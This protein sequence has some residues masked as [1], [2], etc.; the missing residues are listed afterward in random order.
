MPCAFLQLQLYLNF[1]TKPSEMQAAWST[2]SQM[3]TTVQWGSSPTSLTESATGNSSVYHY[4]LYTS[5]WQ[6][7]AVMTGL[8]LNTKYFYRVGDSATNA[9]SEVSSF[10]SNPGAGADID[11]VFGVIGDLGQTTYSN[12][13]VSHVLANADVQ[14]VI[15]AG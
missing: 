1:R 15:L 5:S 13:T 2:S 3:G 14:S 6:H 12:D 9:W 4:G 10:T 7:F 8:S 11:Y